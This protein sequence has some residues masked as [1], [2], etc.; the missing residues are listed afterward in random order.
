MV[1]CR[2][3]IYACFSNTVHSSMFGGV[4]GVRLVHI[5]LCA[6]PSPT[7][8]DGNTALLELLRANE[9]Q[10]AWLASLGMGFLTLLRGRLFVG[11]AV[12][13]FA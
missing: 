7:A 9:G 11:C 10:L 2:V 5:L 13:S 8:D 6:S 4:V 12:S 1:D 3:Q